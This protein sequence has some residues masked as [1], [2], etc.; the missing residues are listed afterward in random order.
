VLCS[1]EAARHHGIPTDRWVFPRVGIESSHAVSVICRDR[2]DAWPAMQVLGD[3]AAAWLGRPLEEIEVA[4][5]YSCFPAAVRVQQRALGLDLGGTP[6]VTGGMAFAGGPFNN[7]V[8]QSLVAVAAFLRADPDQLGL[9]TT[10]SGLLTKPGL[11]IWS[12]RP[13]GRPPLLADLAFEVESVTGVV[14]AVETLDG[15]DGTG[16]VA[17]YTVTYEGQD[18]VRV[19][20]VCDTDDGRR[21][22]SISEDRSLAASACAEELIGTRVRIGSGAFAPL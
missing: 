19:V 12:A 16:I 17:T 8:L 20:A 5:V 4:E 6:T 15:Y 14:E 2:I 7:F 10:V 18:P 9:V 22:V 13:D 1:V 21:C 11:G 3:T